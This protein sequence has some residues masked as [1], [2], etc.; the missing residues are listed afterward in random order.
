M[1]SLFK[2]I[3]LF[4]GIL[5]IVYFLFVIPG[6][7]YSVI[8]DLSL[9]DHNINEEEIS[10]IEDKIS[11]SY[12]ITKVLFLFWLIQFLA[13]VGLLRWKTKRSEEDES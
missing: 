11:G 7:Q 1:M 13:F 2:L 10:L 12:A 6:G 4:N 3:A 9:L 5:L 8:L